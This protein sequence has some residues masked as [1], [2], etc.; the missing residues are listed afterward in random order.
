MEQAIHIRGVTD[1][2]Q[3]STQAL[4][5]TRSARRKLW[6]V[7]EKLLSPSPEQ[8]AGCGPELEEAADLLGL[9]IEDGA[10]HSGVP[11]RQRELRDE[12]QQ[13]RRDLA[14]VTALMEQAARYYLGWAQML[15]AAVGGYTSLGDVPP[16]TVE[17]RLSLEG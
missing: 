7:R 1:S 5:R 13:L 12:L 6:Q 11:V 16:L 3:G 14:V 17:S 10:G 15:G 8:L 2:E 4:E 9:L